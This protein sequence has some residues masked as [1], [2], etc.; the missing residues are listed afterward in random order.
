[1]LA[2]ARDLLKRELSPGVLRRV[3]TYW[4]YGSFYLPRTVASSVIRRTPAVFG[5]P[6]DL[7]ARL[8]AVNCYAPTQMCR[9]MTKYGSDKGRHWHNYTTV[10]SELFA[11]LRDR[12]LRIFELGLGTINP[13]LPSHM[14]A[15][16]KPG[17]SLRG[18]REIFPR[19]LVYGAD[20][21]RDILF[22]E[23]RIQTFYCDQLDAG[24]I[25]DLWAQPALRDEMDIIVDDGLHTFDANVSFL[26]GSLEH[27]RA[28]GV[29][30]VEDIDRDAFEKWKELLPA[31][32]GRFPDHDFA[33]AALPNDYNDSDNNL[34]V[35]AKRP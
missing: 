15:L 2:V 3:T 14:A 13:D 27:L 19:A 34:L 18:W 8:S 30:V 16:G 26:A 1:M 20:I 10:Y 23:D 24:A 32:Q 25:R 6:S 9:V 29:Y 17:A 7:A 33:L 22:T 12:P 31:Y 35:I 4:W 28:G 11:K 21:D 5:R